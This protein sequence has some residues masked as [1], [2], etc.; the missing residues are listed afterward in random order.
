MFDSIVNLLQENEVM[1]GGAVLIVWGA[2]LAYCRHLPKRL[3]TLFSR[4]FIIKVDIPDGELAFSWINL[5]LGEHSSLKR[6]RWLTA[7]VVREDGTSVPSGRLPNPEKLG[8]RKKTRRIVFSPAPG[9]HLL[10]YR[11]RP[12]LLQRNRREL[13][14]NHNNRAFQETFVIRMLTRDRTIVQKLI[15]E[16]R[17]QGITIRVCI[18]CQ[19]PR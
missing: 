12:V 11:G 6:S 5:W 4:Q 15:E 17:A 2:I 1:Q 16:A 18:I 7:A 3:W 10:W 9:A 13:E 14:T 8:T 19:D